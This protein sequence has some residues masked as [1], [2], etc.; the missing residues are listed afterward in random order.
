MRRFG[1]RTN[2]TLKEVVADNLR[3]L[4]EN[5]GRSIAYICRAMRISR[6]QFDRYLAAENLPTEGTAKTIAS[7]FRI[8][9]VDLFQVGFR[10]NIN[11]PSAL[12]EALRNLTH[13]PAPRFPTGIYFLFTQLMSDQSQILCGVVIV[14]YVGDNLGFVRL[15]GY[16]KYRYSTGAY[17]RGR[18]AGI[19]VERHKWLY[20]TAVNTVPEYEPSMMMFRWIM[21]DEDVLPGK[22]SIATE[23]GPVVIDAVL[24]RAP[25]DLSLRNAVKM[26]RTYPSDAAFIGEDV[27]RF[28]DDSP[29]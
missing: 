22:A 18:H 27:R 28:L 11:I 16:S 12:E 20:F 29:V 25:A 19:I 4:C 6:S 21:G 3:R 9:E 5:D 24:K 7:F 14:R 26:A 2:L 10:A 1:E 8:A 23:R 13:L 17:F 15:Q